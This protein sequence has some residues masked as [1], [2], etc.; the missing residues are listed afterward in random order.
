VKSFDTLTSPFREQVA[1]R[2]GAE[3]VVRWLCGHD[4]Q[5]KR[6]VAGLI[7][8]IGYVPVDL[9]GVADRALT[10][11]RAQPGCAAARARPRSSRPSG[12]RT[13][14]TVWPGSLSTAI[15]PRWRSVTIR[16]AASSPS[17]VP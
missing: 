17:P 8:E 7:D 6:L 15:V 11:R 4:A 5:A 3:R 16:R 10:E 9:G 12:S 14:N 13:W 1:T 2:R